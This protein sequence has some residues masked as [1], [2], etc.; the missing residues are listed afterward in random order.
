MTPIPQAAIGAAAKIHHRL[1]CVACAQRQ[2]D[3]EPAELD[4]AAARQILEAAEEAWPPQPPK[5]DLTGT[6]DGQ[7]E[8]G[9]AKPMYRRDAR[10]PGPARPPFGFGPPEV[11]A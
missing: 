11:L 5:R 8:R 4:L 9:P 10:P 7:F 2:C 1:H 3:G 6:T